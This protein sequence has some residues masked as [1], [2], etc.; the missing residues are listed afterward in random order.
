[1]GTSRDALFDLAVNRAAEAAARLGPTRQ[2]GLRRELEV[3][4]LKTRFAYR[5]P[6]EQVLDA[7]RRRPDGPVHWEGGPDGAWRPGPAAT[8]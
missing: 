3:W 7:V 4:Y 5:V 8:P 1:M 2:D 6:F